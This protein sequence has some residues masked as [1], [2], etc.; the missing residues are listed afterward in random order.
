MGKVTAALIIWIASL[1]YPVNCEISTTQNHLSQYLQEI[2]HQFDPNHPILISLPKPEFKD[3]ERSLY[4]REDNMQ[5]VSAILK[6]INW[7]VQISSTDTPTV[8]AAEDTNSPLIPNYI[9]FVWPDGNEILIDIQLEAL[10]EQ[11]SFN[12]RGKY[13]VVLLTLNSREETKTNVFNILDTLW[14]MGS[15]TNVNTVVPTRRS[16]ELVS[17]KEDE[18]YSVDTYTWFPYA[19]GVC[20]E[21]NEVVLIDRWLPQNDR[22]FSKAIDLF[23]DKLPDD[24]MGCTITASSIG[25]EPYVILIKNETLEDGSTVF[26]IGGVPAEMLILL[27]QKMNMTVIFIP[28]TLTMDVEPIITVFNEVMSGMSDI[29]IGTLPLSGSIKGLFDPTAHISYT[30][31]RWVVPCPKQISRFSRISKMYN[32]S[33][34][35]AMILTFVVTTVIFWLNAKHTS[36]ARRFQNLANVFYGTWAVC[37]SV[38]VPFMPKNSKLRILFF[39]YVCYCLAVSNVFQAFFMSYL[40]EPGYHKGIE[41]FEDILS[42]GLSFGMFSAFKFF[43]QTTSYDDHKRLTSHEVDCNALDKCV[44][45]VLFQ[46]DITTVATT[47]LVKYMASLNGIPP[48]MRVE[49]YVKE[50]IFSSAAIMYLRKGSPLLNRLNL[51]LKRC[52]EAGIPD[53]K[54]RDLIYGTYLRSE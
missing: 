5:L 2:I 42:S 49:C 40:V 34:W 13:I 51:L 25:V 54:W 37:M 24:F 18:D 28:P 9:I 35:I 10:Q 48:W 3:P 15:I 45:R 41:T 53:K 17:T 33:V 6:T 32:E 36:D 43:M 46:G 4:P 26:E 20:G 12:S 50:A 27:A 11:M 52:F 22:K 16:D 44:E 21:L 23:P 31:L 14:S 47:D 7:T 8:F 38:S 19:G 39:I 1:Q 30:A 29:L